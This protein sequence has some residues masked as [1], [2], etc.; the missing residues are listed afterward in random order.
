MRHDGEDAQD[1]VTREHVAVKSNGQR[2]QTDDQREELEEPDDRHH[3]SREAGRGDGLDVAPAALGLDAV[4]VEVHER[5]ECQREGDAQRA[6]RGLGTRDEADHVGDEDEEEHG[7]DERHVLLPAMADGAF[8]H[9]AADCVITPVHQA[10][11]LA[12]RANLDLANANQHANEHDGADD[13][14]PRHV[15]GDAEPIA[16]IHHERGVERFAQLFDRGGNVVQRIARKV[17]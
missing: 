14:Q 11:E 2:Q 3:G 17:E 6:G 1:H 4:E 8:A 12:G 16:K 5:N 15:L 7:G 10:G 9:V 13:D